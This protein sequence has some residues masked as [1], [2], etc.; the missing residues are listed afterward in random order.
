MGRLKNM[1]KKNQTPEEG[2]EKEVITPKADEGIEKTETI[3]ENKTQIPEPPKKDEHPEIDYKKKFAESTKEN[4]ILQ[5]RIKE[6]ESQLGF[7]TKDEPPTETEMRKLYPDWDDRMDEEK[8][9]LR[10]QVSLEKRI[11]KA[12]L[13]LTKMQEERNWNTEIDQ[14]L[15]K[16]KIMDEY[17]DLKGRESEFRAF[18]NK[19]TH[20][21]ISLEVL[22]RAFLYHPEEKT[23][24]PKQSHL[25]EKGSGGRSKPPKAS[26]TPEDIRNLRKNDPK[27]YNQLVREKKIKIEL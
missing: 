7:I 12:T 9:I 13:L 22:A 20:R 16:A 26:L 2:T 6:K 18:A 21:G 14:F 5:E 17:S 10:K 4:Q 25:L 3:P 23:P 27:K 15:E 11:N 8:E 24:Q 1:D 19:P